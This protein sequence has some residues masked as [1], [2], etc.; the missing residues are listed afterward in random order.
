[1][2]YFNLSSRVVMFSIC[3]SLEYDLKSFILETGD[4]YFTETMVKKS[5]DRNKKLNQNEPEEILNELDLGDFIEIIYRNPFKHK[6]NNENANILREYF[7][8]IIPIRNRVM[9]TRPLELGDR[10]ILY[11]VLEE[12]EQKLPL[13]SWNATL[14]TRALLKTDP[15]KLVNQKYMRVK[16]F[17]SNVYHN[18]PEPEFDDTGYIGRKN[19]IKEIKRLLKDD[20]NHVITIMGNGGIGKTA[21]AVK[22]LYDLVDDPENEYDAI[23]WISLKTRT[24]ARGEFTKIENSIQSVTDFFS[25]GEKLII[26]DENQTPEQNIVNFMREFKVLLVLD[27]LETINSN[28]IVQF[29]KEVPGSS[30]VLIT[31]RHG[32]G[33]LENR[34]NLQG[35][36]QKDAIVYFRELAK[37]YGV[38]V[39]KK[40]ESEVKKLVTDH[41]YSNP[42]SIKWFITGIHNGITENVLISNKESLIE[43]CMSNVYEKLSDDSKKIL[44][45]FLVE[46]TELSSGE[47]DYF[48]GIDNVK[49]R[50]SINNLLTTNMITITS[51]NFKLN[52]MAKDYLALY[53]SPTN[54]FFMNTLKKRK[55]L[56]NMIQQIKVQNEMDPFNPKSLYKNSEDRNHK[57]SSYYLSKALESSSKQE[58]ED[59]F[60]LIHKAENITPDYFEVYK[61]KAFIQAEKRDLFNALTSYEIALD[62]CENDFE[63]ST[64]LYLYSVFNTIKLSDLE[65]AFSLIEEAES[66]YPDN[67]KI[68]LEKSRVLMYQGLFHESEDILKNVDSRKDEL[69]LQ[70]ENIFV[71]RYAD[72]QRRKAEHI[73]TRDVEKKLDLLKKGINIIE[74]VDR[75]DTKSYVT[76][77]K[78]LKE[79]SFLYFDKNSMEFLFATLEKH[80]SSLK[81]NKSHDLKKMK[82]ILI[83]HRHE[84]PNNLY[85]SLKKYVYDYTVDAKEIYNKNEGIVVFIKEHFGFIANAHNRSIYFNV[86]NIEEGTSVGD[87]V[88]FSTYRNPKGIAAKNIK[89][90]R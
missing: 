66:Y 11:E 54:D 70:S 63:K 69:D 28:H 32:I 55:H 7:S 29:L 15:T 17:E 34:Y 33:E 30:K 83:S 75:I 64:V 42:L 65:K 79:L 62:K 18:L 80:F 2:D 61:I 6:I 45:L 68:L 87:K 48:M 60:A 44:Q 85:L 21:I 82:E 78:I 58:W 4:I 35:L 71:S 57:L 37:F 72:L 81:S 49:L 86:N 77:A 25:S 5:K 47:I 46:N 76:M 23:L 67:L 36:N 41:L 56:N 16:E 26:K 8:K 90:I 88:K 10:A 14:R 40:P 53:H 19:E 27:N 9:H 12:I 20:K 22:S 74:T 39:Y 59:A 51:E 3:T 52:D 73:K 24:L 13:L 1:M 89:L 43:F 31:S 38:S 84:I 50:E